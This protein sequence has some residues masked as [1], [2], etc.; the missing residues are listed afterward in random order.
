MVEQAHELL[1]VYAVL[2]QPSYNFVF[3]I[4]TTVLPGN[5][6][7]D[8]RLDHRGVTNAGLQHG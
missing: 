2:G 1:Y 8:A 5:G 4:L 6:N 7:R 3:A